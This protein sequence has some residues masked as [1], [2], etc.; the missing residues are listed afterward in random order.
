MGT[1]SPLLWAVPTGRLVRML[2][3]VCL[4]NG[5]AA[6]PR[7][8]VVYTPADLRATV[9]QRAPE[10]TPDLVIPFEVPPEAVAR[11]RRLV[12]RYT[13][14][15][16][17]IRALIDALG[18]SHGFA[19]T[20]ASVVTT[21]AAETLATHQGNCL[22]LAS[23]FI[24]LAR[25]LGLNAV[26]VDASAR[27]SDLS[28]PT[29]GLVVNMGHI[30][31]MIQLD[32]RRWY[33][34][35]DQTLGGSPS[36]RVIDDLEAVAHFYNNRGFERIELAVADQKPVDWDEAA[37][38]FARATSVSPGFARGWNNLGIARAR[39]GRLDEAEQAYS[40]AVEVDPKAA[41]AY[42]NLGAL[43]LST[44]RIDLAIGALR[45]AVELEP[46][47]AFIHLNLGR[48]SLLAHDLDA[49]KRELAEAARLRDSMARSLLTKL[50]R[51]EELSREEIVP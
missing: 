5:C 43:Y 4:V 18:S 34:D 41:S 30:T 12:A 45:R 20:Y 50:E 6:S 31:G 9:A 33:L 7:P 46:E 8:R 32:Q 26:Y 36:L 11:A 48:A 35:F 21:S 23:V 40:R 3:A 17:Q 13:A 27:V 15:S 39:A 49:A 42:N 19:L 28:Q 24:G 51:Y 25:A 2:A 22:A 14:R 37:R 38:D 10:L 47:R 29:P 1:C 44:G 16:D